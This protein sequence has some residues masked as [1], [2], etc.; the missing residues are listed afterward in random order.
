MHIYIVFC[1]V[2]IMKGV[3]KMKK[4][5]KK[6]ITVVLTFA[7]MFAMTVPA[8]AKEVFKILKTNATIYSSKTMENRRCYNPDERIAYIGKRKVA[9]RSSNTKVATV[10]IKDNAIWA[11]P[12]KAGTTTI[13]V[14][15]GQETYKCTFTVYKYVNPVSSAM[16]GKTTIKGTAF[17]KNAIYNLRYSKY[18]NKSIAFKFNLKK[19]W[20]LRGGI[21]YAR[22]N[23]GATKMSPN[24]S[25]IKVAGGSGFLAVEHVENIKTGQMERIHIYFK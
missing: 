2:H 3:L 16:V 7:M 20:K 11:T 9:V 19:G 4:S 14:K 22:S 25:K 23:W 8:Y 18:K 13:T 10:K 5:L 21:A 17:K 1:N 12:K 15:T 24:G 6:I